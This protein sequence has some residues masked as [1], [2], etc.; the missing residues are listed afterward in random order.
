MICQKPLSV[1][2]QAKLKTAQQL[3]AVLEVTRAL[4]AS[5]STSRSEVAPPNVVTCGSESDAAASTSMLA[6]TDATAQAAGAGGS[7]DGLRLDGRADDLEPLLQM[8]M[9]LEKGGH[10]D[11][12]NRKVQLKPTRWTTVKTRR[13]VASDVVSDTPAQSGVIVAPVDSLDA[14]PV[15][16]DRPALW[17]HAAPPAAFEFAHGFASP[18]PISSSV[19]AVDVA[20]ASP[21]SEETWEEVEET[22]V[23]ECLLVLKW[24]G[25]LTHSGMKQAEVAGQRFRESM[26]PGTRPSITC[27]GASDHWVHFLS[28]RRKYGTPAPA[29][30]LQAWRVVW[31]AVLCLPSTLLTLP[32][33]C[34]A[35]TT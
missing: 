7:G 24:G 26:Y 12:I 8:K 11:G 3:Q 20:R 6:P 34:S 30:H 13:R 5:K 17:P 28:C 9:V 29:C 25:V 16:S 14:S 4:V 15:S 1:V 21:L 31:W 35:G 32:P 10:F 33:G 27:C 23:T 18:P 19:S 2:M 22:L